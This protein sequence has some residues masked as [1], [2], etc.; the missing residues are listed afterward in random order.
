MQTDRRTKISQ[1]LLC[2]VFG[3]PIAPSDQLPA[4][5]KFALVN[6]RVRRRTSSCLLDLVRARFITMNALKARGNGRSRLRR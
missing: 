6:H 3:R 4:I 5:L 2:L 1:T